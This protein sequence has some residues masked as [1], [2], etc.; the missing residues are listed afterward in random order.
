MKKILLLLCLFFAAQAKAGL[1]SVNLSAD[2]VFAGDTLSIEISASDFSATTDFWFDLV[3]DTSL[4]EFKPSSLL[5]DLNLVDRVLGLDNGIEVE[6]F[7]EASSLLFTFSDLAAAM[8]NFTI[9]KFE[10]IAI[11]SGVTNF[12]IDNADGFNADNSIYTS[13]FT[14]ASSTQVLP[15]AVNEPGHLGILMLA[16]AAMLLLD[17][18]PS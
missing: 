8:G 18:K 4:F 17:R 7:T 13:R 15:V 9:A 3:F 6:L 1:I 5:S 10:L 16:M 12:M 14:S 2:Q 11:K